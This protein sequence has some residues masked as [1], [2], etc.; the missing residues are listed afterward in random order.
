MLV[1]PFPRLVGE[2]LGAK[3]VNT[4]PQSPAKLNK[5]GA[6]GKP[7]ETRTLLAQKARDR[8]RQ[9]DK[10]PPKN[11]IEPI[12]AAAETT[13]AKP[14][15]VIT[16]SE[17]ETPAAPPLDLFSPTSTEPSTAR[18]E[19]RGDTPPPPDLGPDTG[20][21]SFGRA[22]RRSRGAVSYA[23]PSLRDKM[24]RP[25]K[26]LVDAV[27]AEE[28]ARQ[29]QAIESTLIKI[30]QEEDGAEALPSWK[31]VPIGDS[32]AQKERERTETASPLGMKA[33]A[34]ASHL[35]TTV[36]TDRRR[37]ASTLPRN[38][39]EVQ[40]PKSASS[41]AAS[42]IAALSKPKRRQDRSEN[43]DAKSDEVDTH[44]HRDRTSIFDFTGSSPDLA[45]RTIE[46]EEPAVTS[47][48]SRR[49]SS[50]P[51]LSEHGKGSLSISRRTD[52]KRESNGGAKGEEGG[53][54][55]G[56]PHLKNM[57]SVANLEVGMEEM[58]LGRGERGANRRRSM[59]L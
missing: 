14:P 38:D 43:N 45:G 2:P 47:R 32:H 9:K 1:P 8:E 21:G 42:A 23:E 22:S 40:P 59:M 52:K 51:A 7:L 4:D 54:L 27:G 17:P 25:T 31:T 50:V 19:G 34:P 57:K 16:S 36:L 44:D 33:A 56:V 30:K 18:V 13:K 37:R 41:G 24:R 35:P 46:E 3:S 11:P 28:R 10:A 29:A 58:A 53:V 6:S 55:A 39:N 12:K 15:E 48:S 49:H 5:M 26:E 20:T